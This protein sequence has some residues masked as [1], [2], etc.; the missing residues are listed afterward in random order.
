MVSLV[1]SF[2]GYQSK[3]ITVGG[4]SFINVVLEDEAS[5]LKEIVV[6]GYGAVRKEAVTGSVSTLAGKELSEFA[7]GNVTQAL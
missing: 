1:F 2:V 7:T 6:I 5:T 4:R 3:E